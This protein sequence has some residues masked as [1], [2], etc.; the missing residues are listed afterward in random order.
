MENELDIDDIKI[1]KKY[2]NESIHHYYSGIQN[3]N[4]IIVAYIISS[5]N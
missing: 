1:M 2:L 4:C 5:L 3:K